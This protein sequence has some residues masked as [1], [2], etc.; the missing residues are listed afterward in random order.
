MYNNYKKIMN[1]IKIKHPEL[2]GHMIKCDLVNMLKY[3]KNKN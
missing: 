2:N 1:D 3:F